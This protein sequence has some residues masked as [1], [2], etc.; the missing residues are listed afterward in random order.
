[1]TPELQEL[2]DAARE[3][4]R[5]I[6]VYPPKARLFAAIDAVELAA[7]ETTTTTIETKEGTL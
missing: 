4:T 1:M 5:H 2:I 3:A 7:V 6:A